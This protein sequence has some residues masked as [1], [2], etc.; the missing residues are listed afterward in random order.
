MSVRS[1][2]SS[3]TEAND[4]ANTF[5]SDELIQEIWVS[6]AG[7]VTREHI[8]QIATEVASEYKDAKVTTFLPVLIRR[9]TLERLKATDHDG[10]SD[11]P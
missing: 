6:L 4:E 11:N 1:S 9:Q 5:L 10:T 7:E 8:Y 3:A 2:L